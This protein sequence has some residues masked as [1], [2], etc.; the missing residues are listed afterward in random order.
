MEN[1]YKFEGQKFERNLSFHEAAKIL[2]TS[3]VKL[4]ELL[5]K[6]QILFKKGNRNLPYDKFL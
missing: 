5:R 4:L 6:K 1:Y 3:N 2:G